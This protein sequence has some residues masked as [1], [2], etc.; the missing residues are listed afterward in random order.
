MANEQ[1]P[2]TPQEKILKSR[3]YSAQAKR[4]MYL[5]VGI[6]FAAMLGL[7]GYSTLATLSF[8]DWGNSREA[9]LFRE[10]K[11][12]FDALMKENPVLNKKIKERLD[13]IKQ[14]AA[15]S[16]ITTETTTITNST[17]SSTASS[18]K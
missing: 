10:T 12:E 2:I 17:A 1:K 18:T 7:W 16:T 3:A 11:N 4:W 5:G 14:E 6:V 15:S 13:T 9:K 8:F